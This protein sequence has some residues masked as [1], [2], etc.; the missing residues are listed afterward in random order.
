MTYLEQMKEELLRESWMLDD[1]IEAAQQDVN[2]LNEEK[3][4]EWRKEDEDVKQLIARLMEVEK[5]GERLRKEKENRVIQYEKK[6]LDEKE[7]IQKISQLA[8]HSF[9]KSAEKDF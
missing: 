6:I 8:L 2:I 5:E 9:L 4:N 1:H 7:Q 3:E